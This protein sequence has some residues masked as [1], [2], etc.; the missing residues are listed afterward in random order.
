MEDSSP[1]ILHR[2]LG[3]AVLG[4]G[5]G[6]CGGCDAVP[7]PDRDQQPP[8]VSAL[9]VVPDSI[10]QSELEP[11]RIRGSEAKV[12]LG[13][14]ARAADKDGTVERVVFLLEPSSNPQG[15]LSGRLPAI[16]NAAENDVYGGVFDS[17]SVPLIDE[18]YTMRVF[19]VDDDSLS[20]NQV[21]GQFRF[22]P[23][24]SS[25]AETTSEWLLGPKMHAPS[26]KDVP[27]LN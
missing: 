17:L 27:A 22:V 12:E 6:L 3:A 20:S 16:E 23:A 14:L 18:I 13:I 24:D 7:A 15:T 25:D 8:S 2:L 1:S 5:L 10:H 19:A 26:M 21:T 4:V 9:Q 11:G